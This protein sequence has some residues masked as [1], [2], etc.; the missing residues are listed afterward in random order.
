M[1][2]GLCIVFMIAILFL[3]L[4]SKPKKTVH[5]MTKCCDVFLIKVVSSLC[6]SQQSAPEDD[7]IQKLLD[8]I[9]TE[10]S[11]EEGSVKITTRELACKQKKDETPII[12]SFLLQM[13]LGHK[14]VLYHYL[15]YINL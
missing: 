4:R 7:L 13:L 5:A 3:S 9:F 14:Y 6:F 8:L 2:S 11:Q 10:T 15:I 12:R 1:L